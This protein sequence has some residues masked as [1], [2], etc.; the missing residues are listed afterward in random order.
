MTRWREHFSTLLN[1]HGTTN[2]SVLD[3]ISQEPVIKELEKDPTLD[4]VEKALKQLKPGKAPGPDGIPPEVLK[5][6][7]LILRQELHKLL[8]NIWREE[9]V[10][11]DFKNGTIIKLF[12]K[13]CRF[14]CGNYTGA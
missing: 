4:E 3:D 9:K 11:Q 13:N 8:L 5:D 2:P 1:Q 10:P 7:G 12:K 6:G 14:T